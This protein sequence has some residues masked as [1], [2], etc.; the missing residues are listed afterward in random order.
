MPQN[1]FELL[2][3]NEEKDDL[4][5]LQINLKSQSSFQH[6]SSLVV[7]G[8]L[9][10]VCVSPRVRWLSDRHTESACLSVPALFQLNKTKQT[11]SSGVV[12][13]VT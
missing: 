10:L 11:T 4:Q 12:L 2:L 8:F 13:I 3:K 7:N 6:K 5:F 1:V 9:K